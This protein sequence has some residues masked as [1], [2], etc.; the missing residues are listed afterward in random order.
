MTTLVCGSMAYDNI[1][2]FRD[3]FKNHILPDQVHMLSVAFLVPQMRQ[4][5]GGCAGNIVYGM[6]L[7]G[8]DGEIMATVGRNFGHYAKW[9]EKH[10]ISQTYIHHIQEE[11]MGQAFIIND[12]S[13][14]TITAFHP[15]AMGHSHLNS[16]L[17]AKNIT[18]G[19]IAPDGKEGMVI[20]A[21]QCKEAGI[22]FIFDPGQQLPTFSKDELILLMEQANYIVVNDYEWEMVQKAT[23]I[24]REALIEKSKILIITKGAEG[25]IILTPENRYEIPSAKARETVDPTGCG[26]AYRAGL[27]Y[28]IEHDLDWEMTGRIAGLMGT[29]KIEHVGSQNYTFTME[30]FENRFEKEFGQEFKPGHG[31]RLR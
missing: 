15:G 9:L 24:K 18:L 11:L 31:P 29:I 16:V 23:G 17:D 30:E 14:S 28:G 8:L 6:K 3:L 22:P 27:I 12:L 10:G 5:Y 25:S 26:D 13:G 19:V 7:L 21:K 4:E 1:M 2:V 20:H